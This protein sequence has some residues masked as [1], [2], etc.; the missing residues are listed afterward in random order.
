[1]GKIFIPSSTF[2]DG[3]Y[4]HC[5]TAHCQITR[6]IHFSS[7]ILTTL[8]LW[9]T[10]ILHIFRLLGEELL[11]YFWRSAFYCILCTLLIQCFYIA[12]ERYVI[13]VKCAFA[14]LVPQQQCFFD[15]LEK[16]SLV[17]VFFFF[18]PLRKSL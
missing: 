1:M 18:F 6:L 16:V 12:L 15:I 4:P 11:C 2:S 17:S 8:C 5:F 10:L 3:V 9:A 7:Y 13:I 14:V